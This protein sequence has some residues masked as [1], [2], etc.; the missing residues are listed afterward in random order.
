MLGEQNLIGRSGASCSKCNILSNMI[1]KEA[2]QAR[3]EPS[4]VEI[5]AEGS[6]RR[7][8]RKDAPLTYVVGPSSIS[9]TLRIQKPSADLHNAWPIYQVWGEASPY[10]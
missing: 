8:R 1:L 9:T 4:D 7:R 5:E 3:S 2:H 10:F 6:S